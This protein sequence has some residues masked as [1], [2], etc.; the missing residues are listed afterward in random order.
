M[1]HLTSSHFVALAFA[2]PSLSNLAPLKKHRNTSHK[3]VYQKKRNT[4]WQDLQHLTTSPEP[5]TLT[6]RC[7]K[8]ATHCDSLW[9]ER[10]WTLLQLVRDFP[11]LEMGWRAPRQGELQQH[12][13]VAAS[14]CAKKWHALWHARSGMWLKWLKFHLL[15]D[16]VD[17]SMFF[18]ARKKSRDCGW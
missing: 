17:A 12:S 1:S 6:L 11:W 10:K 9:S 14:I 7:V 5:T 18:W 13:K 8:T 4:T 16:H 3:Q 15:Y 2:F